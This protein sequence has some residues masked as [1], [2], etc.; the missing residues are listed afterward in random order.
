ML[1]VRFVRLCVSLILNPFG[2]SE[3]KGRVVPTVAGESFSKHLRRA[4]N[5]L[6]TR[7]HLEKLVQSKP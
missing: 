3:G 7:A 4:P 5:S 6:S 2:E 1:Y